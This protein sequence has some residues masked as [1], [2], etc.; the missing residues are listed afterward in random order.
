MTPVHQCVVLRRQPRVRVHPGVVYRRSVGVR[1][2]LVGAQQPGR[3][4]RKVPERSEAKAG[5]VLTSEVLAVRCFNVAVGIP[6]AGGQLDCELILD[7]GNIH[8]GPGV[9]SAITANGNGHVSARF[10]RA[11][12]FGDY[13]DG[14]AQRVLAIQGPLRSAQHFD[15][16]H[17]KQ[18]EE[19][20]P[21]VGPVDAI[22][23]GANTLIEIDAIGGLP[24]PA[25]ENNGVLRARA[26]GSD[27]QIGRGV[28][29][30]EQ[31]AD[32]PIFEFRVR[33][34]RYGY[35]NIL[36]AFVRVSGP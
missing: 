35:G 10:G 29:D 27:L 28:G 22:H 6:G 33:E 25:D 36:K 34:R 5:I 21:D 32:R 13:V 30:A 8:R 26:R 9:D 2:H 19:A 31:V 15:A 14:A 20:A 12:A 24:D 3:R 11:R 18:V 17:I 16:L 4:V 7:Q 23:I 1:A